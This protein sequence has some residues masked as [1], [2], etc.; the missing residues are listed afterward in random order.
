M[1]EIINLIKRSDIDIRLPEVFPIRRESDGTSTIDDNIPQVYSSSASLQD[2]FTLTTF[3]F[4]TIIDTYVDRLYPELDGES[5]GK[6][7]SRLKECTSIDERIIYESFRISR[8]I[9]NATIH[10]TRG[11]EVDDAGDLKIKYT[12]KKGTEYELEITSD[13]LGY[14]NTLIY[15]LID[16]FERR[17][18]TYTTAFRLSLLSN[19]RAGLHKFNDEHGELPIFSPSSVLLELGRRYRPDETSVDQC[20]D[21]VV[22]KNPF[23]LE[24]QTASFSGVDYVFTFD[25]NLYL[26]PDEALDQHSLHLD[27][28]KCWRVNG[29]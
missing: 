12:H 10:N 18:T 21:V 13:G 8:L 19:V 15:D 24:P 22:I 14:L 4:F 9:R 26:V 6:K 27:E 20:G 2:N 28:L 1:Q 17:T 11:I 29:I 5:Y 23:S 7:L 3:I 25:G 16:P